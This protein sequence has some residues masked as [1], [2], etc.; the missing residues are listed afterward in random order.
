MM[1][2]VAT[3]TMG[4]E[5]EYEG[6]TNAIKALGPWSNRLKNC[7]L[8]ESNFSSGRIRDLVKPH[9]QFEKGDRVFVAQFSKNW[10][11]TGMGTDFPEWLNRRDF[12]IPAKPVG[13]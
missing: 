13:H 12:E 2:F 3:H 10:A 1:Y 4:E 11:G 5:S 6:L 8:V 9:L 7:W